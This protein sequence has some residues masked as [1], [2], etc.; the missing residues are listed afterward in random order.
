[1]P[2]PRR[3][4]PSWSIEELIFTVPLV[5][6]FLMTIVTVSGGQRIGGNPCVTWRSVILA[7]LLVATMTTGTLPRVAAASHDGTSVDLANN[8]TVEVPNEVDR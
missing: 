1:M 3:F 7:Y 5:T 6:A 2:T 4:P 8:A